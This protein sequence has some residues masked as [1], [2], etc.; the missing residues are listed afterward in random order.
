M[1]LDGSRGED[2]ALLLLCGDHISPLI[3]GACVHLP[4]PV[5]EQKRTVFETVAKLRLETT[6]N[7]TLLLK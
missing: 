2:L 5:L 6:T 1:L 4:V 7:K 3:K